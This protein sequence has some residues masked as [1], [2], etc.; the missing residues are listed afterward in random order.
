MYQPGN[1]TSNVFQWLQSNRAQ[2]LNT[3]IT[4]QW[5]KSSI[6]HS[7][8]RMYLPRHSQN[9]WDIRINS[10]RKYTK[11]LKV[12]AWACILKCLI[13]S[14]A[15]RVRWLLFFCL[16]ILFCKINREIHVH[17]F[18][19]LENRNT[20]NTHIPTTLEKIIFFNI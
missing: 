5:M 8:Q 19:K 14:I 12:I 18:L 13:I 9:L 3:V 6:K 10:V 15:N 20:E 7:M 1:P 4:T 11:I 16:K 2:N 17:Y